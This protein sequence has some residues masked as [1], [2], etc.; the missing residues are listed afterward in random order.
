MT[1][2]TTVGLLALCS[3]S[4]LIATAHVKADEI[5]LF[6]AIDGDDN[7]SGSETQPLATI[8]GAQQRIAALRRS[9]EWTPSPIVVLVRAGTYE[10]NAPIAFTEIDSGTAQHP[11]TYRAESGKQVIL[12]GG[13]SLP[14]ASS[15]AQ[16]NCDFAFPN[17]SAV[18]RY[19]LSQLDLP[20]LESD[21]H[22]LRTRSLHRLMSDNGLHLIV[23]NTWQ[24]IVKWPG[25]GWA[26]VDSVGD[27][28]ISWTAESA[29]GLHS[30][31]LRGRS[32]LG[33]RFLAKR[34]GRCLP[35]RRDCDRRQYR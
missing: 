3:A 8:A 19:D 10:L 30:D 12:R 15:V 16:E 6:V 1:I 20:Q 24:H 25:S 2:R 14:H 22:E 32:H 17:K 23:D 33:A 26:K 9:E 4:A 7:A 18:W 21:T 13:K 27:D 34:L 31:G 5:R 29:S 28:S 35:C 11:V